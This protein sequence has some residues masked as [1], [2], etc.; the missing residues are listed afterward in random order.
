[1]ELGRGGSGFLSVCPDH[2]S[3]VIISLLTEAGGSRWSEYH[4]TEAETGSEERMAG[5]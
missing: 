4:F 2:C 3:W 5:S 1:M